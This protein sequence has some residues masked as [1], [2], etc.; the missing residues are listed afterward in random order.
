[1]KKIVLTLAAIMMVSMSSVSMA[2]NRGNHRDNNRTEV[3]VVRYEKSVTFNGDEGRFVRDDDRRYED[4][5]DRDNYRESVNYRDRDDY[6]DRED[7]EYREYR[8]DNRR[9]ND[10]TADRV[11]GAV[12]GAAAMLILTSI[13]H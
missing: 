9:H 7:Y 11:A 3:R 13:S 2:S 4:N 10:R 12:I 5:R 8:H 1:M 6:R